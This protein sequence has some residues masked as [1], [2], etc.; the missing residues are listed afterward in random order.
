M[1]K[2]PAV[3]MGDGVYAFWNGHS[4]G[5]YT[6]DGINQSQE[7]YLEPRVM[8]ALNEFYQQMAHPKEE[9]SEV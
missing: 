9:Q 4:I 7:I 5:I 3:Y 6:Y 8:D 1:Y 2:E